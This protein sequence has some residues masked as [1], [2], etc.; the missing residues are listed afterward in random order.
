[1]ICPVILV[2]VGFINFVY[3]GT[4]VDKVDKVDKNISLQKNVYRKIKSSTHSAVVYD[5]M[6]PP[7]GAVFY[8]LYVL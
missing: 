1:M 5:F 6:Y 3:F 4:R 8:V 7:V 2:C